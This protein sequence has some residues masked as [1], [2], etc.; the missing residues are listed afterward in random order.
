[1][2]GVTLKIEGGNDFVIVTAR[3][4][5]ALI[6]RIQG[7]AVRRFTISVEEIMPRGL[8][9]Y[10]ERLINTNRHAAACFRYSYISEDPIT[11]NELYRIVRTQLE[12]LEMDRTACFQSIVPADAADGD[13]LFHI[14]CTEAFFRVCKDSALRLE[15]ICR[16]GQREIIHRYF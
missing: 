8:E 4:L 11:K 5:S 9:Q 1:M 6:C 10:L 13:I 15:Y 16:E 12:V 2:R 7:L 14:A 3:M